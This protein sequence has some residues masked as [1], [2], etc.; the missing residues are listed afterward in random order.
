MA[1]SGRTMTLKRS[2]CRSR[3]PANDVDAIDFNSVD[4]RDKFQHGRLGSDPFRDI[5]E[6]CA[7]EDN[8]RG[9]E[10]RR[11][12]RFAAL[13]HVDDRRFEDDVWG[14]QRIKSQAVARLRDFMPFANCDRKCLFCGAH[15]NC[16]AR[17]SARGLYSRMQERE[18]IAR[19]F[20]WGYGSI[21]D[22][23]SQGFRE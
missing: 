10:I 8:D 14:E 1:F 7:A 20:A 5:A 16:A 12:D 23:R 3:V 21:T 22:A 15:L 4:D 18:R 17:G 13:R 6:I 11:C 2:I 19:E 9:A